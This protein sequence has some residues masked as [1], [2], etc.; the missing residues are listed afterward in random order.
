M[1]KYAYTAFLL[2]AFTG[3][4]MTAVAQSSPTLSGNARSS[5]KYY[6]TTSARPGVPWLD[7][8]IIEQNR[9]PMHTSFFSYENE[10]IAATNDWQQ[11]RNYQSLNGAW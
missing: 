2:A 1:S 7:E 10:A 4:A 11:S 8:K 9:L 3:H 5:K 6:D